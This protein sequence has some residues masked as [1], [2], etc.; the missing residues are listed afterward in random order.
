MRVRSVAWANMPERMKPLSVEGEKCVM[1]LLVDELRVNFGVRLSGCLDH[2][3]EGGG[4]WPRLCTS[5][6]Y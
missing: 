1:D 3:R 4:G 5:M 6:Q 2:S